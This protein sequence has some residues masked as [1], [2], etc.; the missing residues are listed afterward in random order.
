MISRLAKI[1]TL[2]RDWLSSLNYEKVNYLS[3]IGEGGLKDIHCIAQNVTIFVD[4]S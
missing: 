2:Y 4:L 1:P 3:C